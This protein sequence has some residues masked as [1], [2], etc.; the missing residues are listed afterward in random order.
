MNRRPPHLRRAGN[1]AIGLLMIG[2]V[3][4]F[5]VLGIRAES[6]VV[7]VLWLVAA[8]ATLPFLF[9]RALYDYGASDANKHV[10]EMCAKKQAQALQ[11]RPP[12]RAE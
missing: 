3:V 9:A 5:I 7:G 6:R 10:D 4:L 11:G 2:A 12:G 1:Y 8:F